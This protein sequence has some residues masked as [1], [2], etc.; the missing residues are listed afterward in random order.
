LILID[1]NIFLEVALAQERSEE[2]KM[3]LNAISKGDLEATVTHFT[4]HAM[5]AI[6]GKG[7]RLVE[8]LRNVEGSEGLNVYT[9]SISE[10]MSVALM[11]DGIGIDFDDTLQ[12][13]VAKKIGADSIASFDKHFDG[14]DLPRIEP[15][16]ALNFR[17]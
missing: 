4:I 2:C 9:T 11:A 12:Y 17:R 13:F 7:S 1:T 6:L 16:D 15:R 3:L 5:A 8:F 14:L 10:E